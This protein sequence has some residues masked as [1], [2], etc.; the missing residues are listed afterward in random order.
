M[1]QA[2]NADETSIQPI[3]LRTVTLALA[4][5]LAA[6]LSWLIAYPSAV[7][8]TLGALVGVLA[9]RIK[10]RLSAARAPDYDS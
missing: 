4:V 7:A 3:E 8:L 9:P 1:A 6:V 10:A 5:F 2:F